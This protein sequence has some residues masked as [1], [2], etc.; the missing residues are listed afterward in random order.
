MTA[1]N[2]ARPSQVE[3]H[4]LWFRCRRPSVESLWESRYPLSGSYHISSPTNSLRIV[5]TIEKMLALASDGAMIRRLRILHLDYIMFMCLR[6]GNMDRPNHYFPAHEE[7]FKSLIDTLENDLT[8]D[9]QNKSGVVIPAVKRAIFEALRVNADKVVKMDKISGYEEAKDDIKRAIFMATR[10]PQLTA[11]GIGSKGILLY[12]PPG[13]GKSLL[14]KSTA[15]LSTKCTV[16]KASSADLIEKWM[17]ESEQNV[18]YLFAIAA[19]N[20]PSIIIIDEIES[21]CQNRQSATASDGNARRMHA[22]LP[23]PCLI[24]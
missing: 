3:M 17:G 9:N 11:H 7:H 16:F 22:E 19:E 1:A 18:A 13:T 24:K 23:Q 8:V 2:Q 4:K 5:L 14:A 20:A 10:T 15:A 21:L 12:G 6:H